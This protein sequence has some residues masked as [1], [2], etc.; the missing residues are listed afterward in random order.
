MVMELLE[1]MTLKHRIE[2][3]AFQP[4]QLLELAIQITDGLDV[5]HAKGIIHRDIKPANIFVTNRGQAKILDFGLAKLML[6]R[7][8]I[9]EA[10]GASVI[11]TEARPDPSLTSP[12]MA[13]GTVAYMSPEQAKAEELDDRT[14]LFI[15]CGDVRNDHRPTGVFG[16][17]YSGQYAVEGKNEIIYYRV[18]WQA[19]KVTSEPREVLRLPVNFQLQFFGNVYDISADLSTVVYA[20]PG[21][22][23]D[24]YLLAYEK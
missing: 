2:G 9:L 22:Q 24:I 11:E 3:K 16:C 14:A 7:H 17:H 13:V 12:G 15:R 4:E 1:G 21:G 20:R 8:K 19:G 10:V 5:A 18:G 23:S 6:E